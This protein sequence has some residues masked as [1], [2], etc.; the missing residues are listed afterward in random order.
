MELTR[1][2]FVEAA[3]V[4]GTAAALAG[5]T[6]A[7]A[8][9]PAT[10]ADVVVVGA[11]NAGLCAAVEAAE[12]GLSVV[13]LEGAE[14]LGGTLMATE[15]IFGSGSALQA[16]LG[17]EPPLKYQVVREE[18][19]YTNYRSDALLWG[20]LVDA[21][22]ANIDWLA[23]H[24]VPFSGVD[25]YLGVS[26]FETAHW[27]EN[28]T[29]MMMALAMEAQLGKLGVEVHTQTRATSLVVEDGAVVGV[30]AVDAAGAACR[31]GARAVVLATGGIGNDLPYLQEKSGVDL[32]HASSAFPLI[33]N[34][35]DG[36]RMALEAGAQETPINLLLTL[37]VD[38]FDIRNNISCAACLQPTLYVNGDGERFMAEDLFLKK[39]YSLVANAQRSQKSGAYTI[40]DQNYLDL[41]ETR[42]SYAGVLDTK[43]G[44]PLPD[45]RAE[46]EQALG[47]TNYRVVFKG[48]TLEELATDMGADPALLVAT[49]ER[50][51][52]LCAAG[53]DV[54]FGKDSAFLEPVTTGPFYAV[55]P[56]LLILTS[57]GGVHT[58]RKMQVCGADEQPIPGLYFAGVG[59]C[60][61][62]QETYNYQISGGMNAYC[63]YSGRRAAQEV[64]RELAAQA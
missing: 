54:D 40:L 31:F 38:G 23:A 9:E 19:E 46:L 12:Q 15:V 1:R 16:E 8:D 20:D 63:T 27:W 58:N 52:Q 22:G 33:A 37:G 3:A 14:I 18:M 61:L 24:G 57:I 5:T 45:T 35:G 64:A 21:S 41:L 44:D 10:V 2:T 49:V 50:Y 56:D 26:A 48:E 36:L 53:E 17:I 29:G 59:G 4:A 11:G 28:A 7:R 32:S 6:A 13:L 43:P 51:N 42:G 55:H 30:E 47:A 62:Y 39:L 25:R 60:E 34:V